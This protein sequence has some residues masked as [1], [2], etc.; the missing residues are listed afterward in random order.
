MRGVSHAV[1]L[2]A[3]VVNDNESGSFL[4]A[5]D[6]STGK[7]IWKVARDEKSNWSSPVVWNN[8]LRTEIVTTGSNKVRSYGRQRLSPD[9]ATFAASPWACDGKVYCLSEDGEI[10]VIPWPATTW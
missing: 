5:L 8:G 6:Q 9:R 10:F 1:G 3:G 7:Q 2:G 4:L